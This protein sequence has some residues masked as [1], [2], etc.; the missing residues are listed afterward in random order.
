MLFRSPKNKSS[1]I[2][3]RFEKG[4]ITVLVACCMVDEGMDVPEA[5]VLQLL[6]NVDSIRLW[7]QLIGRV[8][9]PSPGKDCFYLLDHTD[10][11]TKPHLGLPDQEVNWQLNAEQAEPIGRP[12]LIRDA[13]T[14]E[15]RTDG[16]LPPLEVESTETQ[17][18]EITPDLM[19]RK[20]PATA[21]RLANERCRA[22]IQQGARELRRWLQHLD[23]LEPETLQRLEPA[24]G[25]PKGWAQEIGRAHV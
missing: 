20:H 15:V 24:L 4:E 2:F 10:S 14:G 13:E 6:R 9:R 1:A 11:W 18:V 16:E 22:E 21:R 12:L 8:M 3:K 19:A 5:A 7:K 17:M 25:L 23:V